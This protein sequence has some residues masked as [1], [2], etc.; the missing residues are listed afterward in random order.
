MH[1]EITTVPEDVL[2]WMYRNYLNLCQESG[3]TPL[4]FEAYEK[5]FDAEDS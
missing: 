3:E 5:A 2:S 1:S 4:S